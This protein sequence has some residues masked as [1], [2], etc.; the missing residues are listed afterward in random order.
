MKLLNKKRSSLSK[1]SS[2]FETNLPRRLGLI[3]LSTLLA[4]G[5]Y[6][7]VFKFPWRDSGVRGSPASLL[8]T[9]DQTFGLTLRDQPKLLFLLTICFFISGLFWLLKPKNQFMPWVCALSFWLGGSLYIENLVMAETHAHQGTSLGLF[10]MAFWSQKKSAEFPKW[11]YFLLLASLSSLYF[12]A[13]VAK[14]LVSGTVWIDGS[15]LQ[16]VLHY[17]QS[18]SMIAVFLLGNA[19][20]ASAVQ[21][22]VLALELGALIYLAFPVL[23]LPYGVLLSLFHLAIY[24]VFGWLFLG[25]MALIFVNLLLAP[26]FF[27]PRLEKKI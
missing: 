15:G 26:L 27:T 18:E 14:L 22:L 20:Y 7:I 21:T 24:L 25:H 6:A 2:F 23:R 4:C 8:G 3:N 16:T 12:H 13:G 5:A 10:A 17:Y 1:L 19:S 9:I 11:I